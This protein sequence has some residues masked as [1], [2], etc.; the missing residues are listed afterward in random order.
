MI[1]SVFGG[2]G[3][4]SIACGRN[5]QV[6]NRLGGESSRGRTVLVVKRL[7]GET[8]WWRTVQGAKRPRLGA[9]RPRLGA[10][11]PGGETSKWRNVLLPPKCIP[12]LNLS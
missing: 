7:G 1:T 2:G 9:K 11:R 12:N 6:A 5:V 4:S 3:E 10:K 8:S